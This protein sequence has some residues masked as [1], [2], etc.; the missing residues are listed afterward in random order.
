MTKNLA[1]SNLAPSILIE[2]A[3]AFP[4]EA[5]ANEGLSTIRVVVS[6]GWLWP[7]AA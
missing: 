2:D 7:P 1:A 4:E 5:G 3:F 6:N